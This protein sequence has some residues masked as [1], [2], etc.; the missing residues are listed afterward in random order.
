MHSVVDTR[1]QIT[2]HLA[3]S[4]NVISYVPCR[5]PV[6]KCLTPVHPPEV[7]PTTLV[8]A[9]KPAEDFPVLGHPFNSLQEWDPAQEGSL[10]LEHLWQ[11][12]P[13]SLLHNYFA[14]VNRCC[15]CLALGPQ[16]LPMLYQQCMLEHTGTL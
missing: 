7:T 5:C 15:M 16:A 2:Y 4:H 8:Q 14:S 12:P 13:G 1:C 11:I 9:G 6:C 3:A 10:D